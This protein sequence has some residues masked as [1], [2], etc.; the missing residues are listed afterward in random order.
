MFFLKNILGVT[1][2]ANQKTKK[3]L[4]EKRIKL[5]KSVKV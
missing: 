1:G 3:A 2:D 4:E 5:N